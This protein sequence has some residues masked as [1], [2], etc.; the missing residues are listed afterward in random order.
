[1]QKW[2]HNINFKNKYLESF[3]LHNES[4]NKRAESP[5]VIKNFSND[6]ARRTIFMNTMNK[7][8][9]KNHSE[10]RRFHSK[11]MNKETKINYETTHR[12]ILT[13]K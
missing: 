5:N 13:E 1:M 7:A 10:I 6:S 12:K 4:D 2:K 9:H 11:S 8:K 3:R